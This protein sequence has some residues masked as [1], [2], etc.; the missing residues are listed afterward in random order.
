MAWVGWQ[1]PSPTVCVALVRRVN[2]GLV[3]KSVRGGL[4]EA[5]QDLTVRRQLIDVLDVRA[6]L[7]LEDGEKAVYV[8]CSL[9]KGSVLFVSSTIC[10]TIPPTYG[11]GSWYKIDSLGFSPSFRRASRA[12][13]S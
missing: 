13:T 6:T 5:D 1:G 11:T 7:A 4:E 12:S 3:T 10:G 9:G 8:R 2:P